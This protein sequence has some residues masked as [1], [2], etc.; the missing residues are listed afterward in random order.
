MLESTAATLRPHS[1]PMPTISSASS[2]AS[3]SVFM[4]AP[5]P[6]LTSSTMECAPAASF[7]DMM[8]EAMSGVLSTVAVTSRRA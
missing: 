5:E 7:F 1:L 4:K 8:E 6:T 3:S 2:R